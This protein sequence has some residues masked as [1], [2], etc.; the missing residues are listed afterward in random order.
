MLRLLQQQ[1]IARWVLYF[2]A[3]SATEKF[4]EADTAQS[5]NF[6]RFSAICHTDT[7]V[8]NMHTVEEA[9]GASSVEVRTQLNH[10]YQCFKMHAATKLHA[11]WHLNWFKLTPTQHS[12]FDRV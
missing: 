5:E 9:P 2:K 10:A 1:Q 8:Y 4:D 6:I 12:K 3:K 11:Y 7:P